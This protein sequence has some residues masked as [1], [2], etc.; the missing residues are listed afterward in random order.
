MKK[1]LISIC[2]ILIIFS[3]AASAQIPDYL[4]EDR[5][6]LLSG[7]HA[8]TAWYIDKNSVEVLKEDRPNYQIAVKVLTVRYDFFSGEIQK[9]VGEKINKYLYQKDAKKMYR[10]ENENWQYI[11]PVGSLAETGNDAIGEMTFY[12]A[13]DEK[14]YGGQK[15]LYEKTGEWKS[16]NFGENIYKIVDESN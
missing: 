15:W 16:P 8:G 3:Q 4:D 6:I 5:T 10:W 14:F 2:A 7:M 1:I 12:I 11:P 9:V 13:Y